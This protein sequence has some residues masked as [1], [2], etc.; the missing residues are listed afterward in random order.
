V[1]KEC[2]NLPNNTNDELQHIRK[3]QQE[4]GSKYF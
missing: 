2:N 1:V 3:I 4:S